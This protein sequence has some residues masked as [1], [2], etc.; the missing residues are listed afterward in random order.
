MTST[1]FAKWREKQ[2]PDPHG[3][4]YEQDIKRIACGDMPSQV[5]AIALTHGGQ[6]HSL[7]FWLTAAKEHL[8]WLSRKLYRISNNHK[9][10]NEYRA[11]LPLGHLTDD[12]LANKFFLS[13][14]KE[15]LK[16]GRD[17]ILWLIDRINS[18]EIE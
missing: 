7:I 3:S 10:I 13:E 2:E 9:D 12:E 4:Y 16:A 15:D 17:R 11:S 18:L 6:G 5:I 14:S 1:P 8:R